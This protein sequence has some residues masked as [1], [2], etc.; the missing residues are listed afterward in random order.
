ML[1]ELKASE[2]LTKLLRSQA[3]I[4]RD[5]SHGEGVNGTVARDRK[6]NLAIRHHGVLALAHDSKAK[7][8][9]DAH[10]GRVADAGQLGHGSESDDVFFHFGDS[11]FFRLD[12]E[13]FADGDLYVFDSLF[14]RGALGMAARQRRATDRPPFRGLNQPNSVLHGL[15]IA[16]IP[17]QRNGDLGF[18]SQWDRLTHEVVADNAPFGMF[19]G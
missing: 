1:T 8:G 7:L 9:K 6:A 17:L 2:N 16:Q 4:F 18:Q 14:P 12:F 13:P 5:A 15:C 11:G 10:R 19:N 3:R